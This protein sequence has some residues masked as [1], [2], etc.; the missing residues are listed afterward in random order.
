MLQ[1]TASKHQD[2]TVELLIDELVTADD[3]LCLTAE[4][5]SKLKLVHAAPRLESASSAANYTD[6]WDTPSSINEPDEGGYVGLSL[7]GELLRTGSLENLLDNTESSCDSTGLLSPRASA[8]ERSYS[9]DDDEAFE[10]AT[11]ATSSTA[12]LDPSEQSAYTISRIEDQPHEPVL[13]RM[14]QSYLGMLPH[15]SISPA[16]LMQRREQAPELFALLS[17]AALQPKTDEE[18]AMDTASLVLPSSDDKV[19]IELM[20]DTFIAWDTCHDDATESKPAK[21]GSQADQRQDPPTGSHSTEL[22]IGKSSP[23]SRAL[24]DVPHLE[25]SQKRQ[26]TCEIKREIDGEIKREIADGLNCD[27]DDLEWECDSLCDSHSDPSSS[28]SS[29]DT[30]VSF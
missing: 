26:R 23:L 18:P 6:H 21:L 29:E 25:T 20:M 14:L 11:T 12:S 15:Q 1:L 8:T 24:E 22:R 16:M 7:Y 2:A 30:E 19:E 17:H 3:L 28:R 10:T 13:L 27:L 9:Y 5:S 4:P